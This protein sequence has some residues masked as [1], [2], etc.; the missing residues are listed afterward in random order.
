MWLLLL[1]P[2][3]RPLHTLNA[4]ITNDNK[5]CRDELDLSELYQ[6]STIAP[7]GRFSSAL[8][9]FLASLTAH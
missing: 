3:D 9:C 5:G 1:S 6:L 2:S 4:L 7:L 8:I